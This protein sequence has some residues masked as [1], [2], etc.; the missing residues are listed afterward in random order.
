[1]NSRKMLFALVCVMLLAVML[2]AV[3]LAASVDV[4]TL[5]DFVNAMKGGATE[6]NITGDFTVD[7]T[8][9]YIDTVLPAGCTVNGNSHVITITYLYNA[10]NG[11]YLFSTNG[12]CVIKDLTVDATNATP[13]VTCH[14]ADLTTG[15]VLQNVTIKG[16]NA[17][18]FGIITSGSVTITDSNFSDVSTGVYNESG[19]VKITGSTFNNCS[20]KAAYLR[21]NGSVFSNNTVNNSDVNAVGT[22][23]VMS[24][25]TFN[26]DTRI[27]FYQEP[28]A[29]NG[30]HINDESWIAAEPAA[31][32]TDV[33][34]NIYE[35]I[36]TAL[37]SNT[38]SDTAKAT[39]IAAH[40]ARNQPADL[41]NRTPQTGDNS[42]IALWIAL[43]AISALS[44]VAL[45]RKSRFN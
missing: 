16:G 21:D 10:D 30:N 22:N 41:K 32:N 7:A 40:I 43:M 24:G 19:I 44:F 5:E 33:S 18:V 20:D 23:V 29:F 9:N 36:Y 17:L 12:N 3:S 11:N 42:N 28:A 15:D 27:K 4:D 45:G 1:M 26:G 25:N 38:I 37:E 35:D 31:K 13:T 39:A 6:I 14:F 34:N 8:L 2:P